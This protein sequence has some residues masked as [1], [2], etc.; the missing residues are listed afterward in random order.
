[1]LTSRYRSRSDLPS[2]YA[3]ALRRSCTALEEAS[4]KHGRLLRSEWVRSDFCCRFEV[5]IGRGFALYLHSHLAGGFVRSLATEALV[6]LRESIGFGLG[7]VR[8]GNRPGFSIASALAFDRVLSA[9]ADNWD[10]DSD[11]DL[12]ELLC[13]LQ[14][15]RCCN[16]PRV[17]SAVAITLGKISVV[18]AAK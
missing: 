5:S 11:C 3:L 12:N 14:T 13:V 2:A 15:A 4:C 10:Q 17:T 1:M 16:H 6:T 18:L 8:H 9:F 7:I